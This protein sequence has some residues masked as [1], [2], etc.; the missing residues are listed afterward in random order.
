[1]KAMDVDFMLSG[2]LLECK[3]YAEEM[4]SMGH[5]LCPD[6]RP[7]SIVGGCP[8]LASIMLA[9]SNLPQQ[10]INLILSFSQVRPSFS[11]TSFPK[12]LSR[13][14]RQI[15]ELSYSTKSFSRS[16]NDIISEFSFVSVSYRYRPWLLSVLSV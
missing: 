6:S 7:N 16:V 13:S 5:S 8:K 15:G 9:G 10:V 14:H 2:N 4:M 1:M 3:N 12:P 11:K